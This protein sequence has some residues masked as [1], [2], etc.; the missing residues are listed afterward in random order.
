MKKWDYHTQDNA[1]L[2]DMTDED[3]MMPPFR[4]DDQTMDEDF[5]SR[6]MEQIRKTEI[7]PAASET[8][9]DY[10]ADPKRR[11]LPIAA[12]LAGSAA[13]VI[14]LTYLLLIPSVTKGPPQVQTASS[15]RLLLLPSEWTDHRLLE[16]K[17]AGVIKQ[18]DIEVT[19]QGY[20]LTLQ[21]VVA[22][23]N[24]M[25]LNLRI[26]DASGLPAEEMMARFDVSQLQLQNEQGEQIG[27]LQ[28]INHMDTKLAGDQFRQEYL[29]LTYYF[30]NE[31]PGDT[32]HVVGMVHEL[33]K[34]SKNN[35]PIS[36]DWS[37]SYAA[38]MTTAKALT[39]TT[40][41]NKFSYAT[42][43]GLNIQMNMITHSPAGV[44]L[45]FSTTLTAG[46]ASRV[47]ENRRVN[48]GVKY[49]FEDAKGQTI[50]EPVSSKY[51]GYPA[52]IR[53][54]QDLQIHWTYYM[55]ELPYRN[56]PVYFVLDGFSIPVKTEDSLTFQPALL[57]TA[58]AVFTAQGDSLNVNTIKI[59]ET[60]AMPGPSAWMAISGSFRNGFDL[61]E[62][63]ARDN[64]G[65][66]Y[67]VFRW[68]SYRDGDPVTF[69]QRDE[70]TDL[71]Y[72]IVDGMTSV[73]GELTLIRTVTEMNFTD[74]DWR[75]ELPRGNAT[76][77]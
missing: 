31:P 13:A 10:P 42:K 70:N 1:K 66:E 53:D 74:V 71:V 47:P 3:M 49:H 59:T 69:G 72:L 54:S 40:D 63:T 73:P 62:W 58:A 19:D 12:L 34:D 65:T 48:L 60:Q 11:K 17:K 21:E 50:G 6:V 56:E 4:H 25:M 45:E 36:G 29:L 7:L 20:T 67:E 43:D 38:D 57:K 68:G 64:E 52:I 2:P 15:Q 37:F 76:S 23:P 22:D 75:F 9:P 77:Q 14:V 5:T 30:K 46:L 27:D 33:M 55:N 24:R 16:A 26:T 41:L 32:V 51:S 35:A 28:S 39:E 44:K 61:D 18:P 8:A